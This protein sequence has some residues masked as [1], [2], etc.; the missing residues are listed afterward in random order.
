MKKGILYEL[1]NLLLL[2]LWLLT[3]QMASGLVSVIVML[4][5]EVVAHGGIRLLSPTPLWAWIAD[6]VLICL[7]WLL[8][9][10]VTSH[11]ARP[12]PAGTVTVLT[13]WGVLTVLMSSVLYLLFVAQ[14]TCD[15]MLEQ[16]FRFLGIEFR[17]G[18]LWT[19]IVGCFLP[20]A[21]FGFG[22]R[23]GW[24]IAI[25]TGESG[26]NDEKRDSIV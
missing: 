17:Y 23:W 22:L 12:S 14:M 11:D 9:G 6:G 7:F 1:K 16:V 21:A 2:L 8:M 4:V 26:G 13:L 20:P 5:L 3:T 10:R 19:L 18:E 24:K 25:C 15:G